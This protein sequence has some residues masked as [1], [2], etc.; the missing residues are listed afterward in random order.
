MG[1]DAERKSSKQTD[2]SEAPADGDDSDQGNEDERKY[3]PRPR[4]RAPRDTD[5]RDKIWNYTIGQWDCCDLAG[6][7]DHV[8]PAKSNPSKQ[9]REDPT[10]AKLKLE[11]EVVELVFPAAVEIFWPGDNAWYPGVLDN[12]RV[13]KRGRKRTLHHVTY[14]DGDDLWHDMEEEQWR[15]AAPEPATRDRKLLPQK[16]KAAQARLDD[17][18]D[19]I[20][21]FEIMASSCKVGAA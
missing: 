6:S 14:D 1:N 11:E 12:V 20:D 3:I 8:L 2:V 18:C 5:G 9:P 17:D 15:K 19:S 4:G 10:S 16:R 21:G 13:E 7:P